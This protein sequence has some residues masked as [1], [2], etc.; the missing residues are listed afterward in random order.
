M[1]FLIEYIDDFS[2]TPILLLCLSHSQDWWLS[3]LVMKI[4]PNQY[5]NIVLEW[6]SLEEISAFWDY[7][8]PG[9][10]V[11]ETLKTQILRRANGNP[12]HLSQI[13]KLLLA[14]QGLVNQN[15]EWLVMEDIDSVFIPSPL[16]GVLRARIDRLNVNAREILQYAAVLGAV[17]NLDL[18]RQMADFI[19]HLDYHLQNLQ[20]LRFL[21]AP[22]QSPPILWGK[23]GAEED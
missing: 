12:F 17:L 23:G 13:V 7:L 20:K 16:E 6:M 10:G 1:T 3:D 22:P 18:L 8:L 5:E 15:D 21:P 14:D 4:A 11:P 2:D 9:K 19:P